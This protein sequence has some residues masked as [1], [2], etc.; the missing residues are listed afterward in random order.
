MLKLEDFENALQC[1]EDLRQKMQ[2]SG[3]SPEELA[4]VDRRLD[5]IT[6]KIAH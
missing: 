4:L 6:S 2:S 3:S 1:H 5:V